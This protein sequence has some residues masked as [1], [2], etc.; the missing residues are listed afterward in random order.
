MRFSSIQR[1]LG[2]LMMIFSF[3]L[4]PPVLVSLIYQDHAA[5]GFLIAF[6]VTVTIGLLAWLPVRNIRHELRLQDGFVIVALFWGVL[7][8]IG[9]LPFMLSEQPHMS[10]TDS[11][12]ESISGLTTTGATVIT[13]LDEMPKAILFYRQQLQWLGGMGIIV[14]AVA[15]LPMLRIGG[16]QLYK[17]ETPGPMKDTKL[18]PRITETAKALW[19]IY[20]SLTIVCALAYWLAGMTLFDAIGHAFSTIAIGGF[21]THDASMGFFENPLIHLIAIVFMFIAGINFALHFMAYR[22]KTLRDYWHDSEFRFYSGILLFASIAV[23]AFLYF[24][25]IY[26][27]RESVIKG[28]FQLVSFATTSGFTT[29]DFNQW[30]GFVAIL[31]L[32]TSFIGACAGS[33]GGGIK[34]IRVLL[35]IKQGARE[36]KRLI[37]PSAQIP[38]RVGDKVISP[39]VIDAVWGFFALYVAS[40]TVM[41]LALAATG[42]D[43]MTAFSAV[44]AAMN[45]LGPGLGSV[46]S[47]YAAINDPAKWILCFGMLLG[48]L[49]IFTLLVLLSPGFWRR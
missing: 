20:L 6:F 16:M 40:Y 7:S 17:A 5:E 44:A 42:L 36:V 29:A 14:L 3:T 26:N 22:G 18:T 35:L 48:R 11:F 39:R 33:T 13:N 8:L 21:S 37:H 15:V 45:N 34:V 23:V 27:G 30:P 12:F 38:V 24:S 1:I 47:N 2:I 10:L 41:Y 32:F 25:G 4:L 49:E 46:S 19:I 9:S 31:L 43:L 28:V